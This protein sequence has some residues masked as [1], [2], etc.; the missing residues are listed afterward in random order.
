LQLEVC[1]TPSSATLKGEAVR[2]IEISNNRIDTNDKD[3]ISLWAISLRTP[4]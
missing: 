3:H 4:P 1:E 2:S